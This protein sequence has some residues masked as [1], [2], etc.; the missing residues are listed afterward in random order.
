MN[1]V[2]AAARLP[3]LDERL[4][5]KALVRAFTAEESA[6][7]VAHRLEAAGAAREIFTPDAV[8]AMHYLARGIARQINRLGDL[9]LVVGFAD[10]LP[11]I[12]AD[13]IE[14]VSEELVTLGGGF[15]PH[16]A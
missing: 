1:L 15:V 16:A 9:A 3:S 7:Y 5:V 14:S 13:Q 8:E 2:S 10:R 6:Q 11:R 12:T 4:A